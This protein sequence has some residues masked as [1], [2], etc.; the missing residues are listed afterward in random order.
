MKKILPKEKRKE[1]ADLCAD[2]SGKDFIEKRGREEKKKKDASMGLQEDV[3]SP[4]E[5]FE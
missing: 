4:E 2:L 1:V 3:P 5:S